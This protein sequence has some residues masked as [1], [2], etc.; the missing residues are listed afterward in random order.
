MSVSELGVTFI[1]G[2]LHR[3][4]VR[5]PTGSI[6]SCHGGRLHE[7]RDG[8]LAQIASLIRTSIMCTSEQRCRTT[9]TL[10]VVP[11]TP[12]FCATTAVVWPTTRRLPW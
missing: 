12:V 9:A 11:T 7:I 3:K 6:N 2:P 5:I 10:Q 8:D 4:H 1:G